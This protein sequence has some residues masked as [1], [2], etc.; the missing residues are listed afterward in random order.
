MHRPLRASPLRDQSTSYSLSIPPYATHTTSSPHCSSSSPT[1]HCQR[2]TRDQA[3]ADFTNSSPRA[4]ESVGKRR[5][6]TKWG[7]NGQ[8]WHDRFLIRCADR[9][10]ADRKAVTD[11][12]RTG[13][14]STED[15]DTLSEQEEAMARRLFQRQIKAIRSS[16][17]AQWSDEIGSDV[18][19]DQLAEEW[20][21]NQDEGVFERKNW[22]PRI[23]ILLLSPV[24]PP[25]DE[26]PD[27][28]AM[29]DDKADYTPGW[30]D[31]SPERTSQDR[32]LPSIVLRSQYC[33][34]CSQ[35]P[36]SRSSTGAIGCNLCGWSVEHQTLDA[37]DDWF[38]FHA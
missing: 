37:A 33:P 3:F 30:V 18:D 7:E 28:D 23:F 5:T 15:D 36:L 14:A 20:L 2:A 27:E 4:A 13:Y 34:A 1:S 16:M 17:L 26:W 10:R 35:S 21:E 25:I 29:M 11:A 12:R 31:D 22:T 6:S 38:K 19:L 24:E 9:L 32:R 8:S